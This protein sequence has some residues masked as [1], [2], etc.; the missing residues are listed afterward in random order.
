MPSASRRR[1]QQGFDHT[2]QAYAKILASHVHDGR[3]DYQRLAADRAALV[4]ITSG[5]GAVDGAAERAWT[6]EERLAFWINAYN[7]FTLQAIVDHYPIRAGWFTLGPRNSIRQI[8]G[9]WDRLTWRVAGR[10]VTLDDIEHR[11]IR[12]EFKEP[13][14]HFAVNCASIGCPPL[15]SEPYRASSLGAQLDAN[16]R[17]YLASPQG[18][19]VDAGALVVTSILKWYG[20]DFVD[21]FRRGPSGRPDSHPGRDSPR[22][23]GL[24]PAA[25][26]HPRAEPGGADSLPRL[27]LDAQR[28]RAA[29]L[30]GTTPGCPEIEVVEAGTAKGDVANTPAGQL[31]E[32]AGVGDVVH[33]QAHGRKALGQRVGPSQP[34]VGSIN[35]LIIFSSV[36]L[37]APD[38]PPSASNLPCC[39]CSATAS[40]T[41][42]AP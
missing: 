40:T 19:R 20:D 26:R 2:Y 39:T 16:A 9:V 21:R 42:V 25:G 24:R 33:E 18:L 31:G 5:F 35:R 28:R 38:P 3:V 27:R 34:E 17:S 23:G 14:I 37:P 4:D 41:V 30:T 13:R 22:R 10:S 8:A 15:R 6:R 32:H 36:V 11:I 7:L 12:P 29:S 1:R